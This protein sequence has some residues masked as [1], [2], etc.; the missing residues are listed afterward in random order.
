MA[1]RLGDLLIARGII[2]QEDVDAALRRQKVIGGNM[3]DNLVAIGAISRKE[4]RSMLTEAPK[5]PKTVEDTGLSLQFLEGLLLKTVF[6]SGAQTVPILAEMIKLSHSIIEE[7][8]EGLKKHRWVEII[9]STDATGMILRYVLTDEGR[10]RALDALAQSEYVG[11][12]PIP[13]VRYF[14]QLDK[15]AI[16]NEYVGEETLRRSL[17]HLVLPDQ[18]IEDLGPAINSSKAMLIYGPSGNG[19]SSIASALGEVL[20]QV[21]YIPHAI[22]IDHQVIKIF[23]PAL[24]TSVE[25][26]VSEN[27]S[28]EDLLFG[29]AS[30]Y[31]MRWVP[32][33]RPVVITG[34]ELTL[35]ML[36]LDFNPI[37]KFYEAPL[38]MKAMG[39]LFIIDDFGRQLVQPR[40]LLNRWIVPLENR[41]DYLT[42]HTGKKFQVPFDAIVVFSTNLSPKDLMDPAL[43]R[44]IHYKLQIEAPDE[45]GYREIFRRVCKLYGLTISED[46]LD[47]ILFM[48][49]TRY[50]LE[51]AAFH[52]KFIVEHA[53]A[54]CKYQDAPIRLSSEMIE[55]A[56]RN[57][58]VAEMEQK[59]LTREV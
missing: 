12:A 28:D 33:R 16:G 37:A 50:Q 17:S 55:S 15:Q 51:L 43:L 47:E 22:E 40:D 24:H 5:T 4:L 58:F 23:D 25:P 18:L 13:M 26:P 35:R 27:D 31:D 21:I 53:M 32:C 52:P 7:L 45:E 42:L 48:F 29:K 34:G 57:L 9:G 3:G 11:P 39:G 1:M 59:V 10:S 30:A 46:L 8:L 41:V 6:V 2:T 20:K 19:K 44:R 56:I 38:Q 14:A 49:Y 36:D 54:A